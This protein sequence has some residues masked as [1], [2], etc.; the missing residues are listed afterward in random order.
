MATPFLTSSDETALMAAIRRAESRTSVEIRIMVSSHK[1]RDPKA[2]AAHQ[3]TRLKMN[4]TEH[5]NAVLVF[6]APRSKTF[7]FYAGAAVYALL[8]QAALD[9]VAAK[10]SAGLKSSPPV[11]AITDAIHEIADKLAPH[12][13]PT[14]DN[15]NELPDNIAR[16]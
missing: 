14:A 5:A 3:F 7:A 1:A 4:R 2:A 16:D 12:F 8:G 6:L 15:P 9:D 11:T 13:P 10:L